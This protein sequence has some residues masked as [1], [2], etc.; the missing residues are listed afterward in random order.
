MF[1]FLRAFCIISCMMS[2]FY[3]ILLY[4]YRK[5]LRKVL[6]WY[7]ALCFVFSFYSNISITPSMNS[8]IHINNL[9]LTVS[10]LVFVNMNFFSES[11]IR[12]KF[13]PIFTF[14]KCLCIVVCAANVF[15]PDSLFFYSIALVDV[16]TLV[17]YIIVFC[18][19]LHMTRTRSIQYLYTTIGVFLLML[20]LICSIIM[21]ILK[22]PVFFTIRLHSIPLFLALHYVTITLRY[23]D[24]RKRVSALSQSLCET[25]DKIKHSSNALMCTQM[26]SDFLYSTLDLI[27]D[28]CLTDPDT[29]EYLT[30]SLSKYL[31]HTLNFQQLKGIVPL[32][33]EIELIKSY[34]VIEKEKHPGINFSYK[35]PESVPEIYIPPLS[36]QPLI[37]NSIEHGIIPNGGTGKVT[38]T[39]IAYRDYF[40][41]DVS[42]NGIG[43]PYDELKM[44]PDSYTKTARVGLYNI[45]T[46]L[47]SLFNKG[48]VLQSEPGIG[49]SI[50]FVVPPDA[51][52]RIQ[53]MREKEDE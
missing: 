32:E 52:K 18:C 11:M 36:I 45:H 34:V 44:L 5:T 3:G 43:I 46:R 33:N 25:I 14:F 9:Y 20:T 23:G 19:S 35:L 12:V 53:E 7:V 51:Q 47:L 42:D 37:E 41:I 8:F 10:S 2:G 17:S 49:T 4:I 26:K 27:S 31:R 13:P 6:F 28:R 21:G 39:V 50:S 16:L 1:E 29:A 38:L 48:L 24:S 40:H 30:V 22:D 15:I